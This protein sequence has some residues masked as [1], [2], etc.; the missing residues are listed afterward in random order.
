MFIFI[1]F[2]FDFFLRLLIL[3]LD[4]EMVCQVQQQHVITAGEQQRQPAF[5]GPDV[6]ARRLSEGGFAIGV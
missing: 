4:M 1:Y 5:P 3:L 6:N 2:F